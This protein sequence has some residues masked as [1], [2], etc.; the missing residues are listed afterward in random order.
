MPNFISIV[1]VFSFCGGSNFWLS[2]RKEKSPL[3]RGL[4]YRSACDPV[5]NHISGSVQLW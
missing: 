1:L 3:A 2:H 5:N 4:N